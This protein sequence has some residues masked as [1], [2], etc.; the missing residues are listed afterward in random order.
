MKKASDWVF[1]LENDGSLVI[2]N[3]VIGS[4][5]NLAPDTASDEEAKSLTRRIVAC[6]KA[7]EGIEDPAAA[8]AV[9]DSPRTESATDMLEALKL[10]LEAL[11][12]A[13]NGAPI[14]TR[15]GDVLRS[16]I[17]LAEGRKGGA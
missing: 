17:A 14:D 3:Q 4:P 1:G 11:T 5:R 12:D 9:L 15:V 16:A 6:V 2:D 7:M 8:R 13:A 10:A